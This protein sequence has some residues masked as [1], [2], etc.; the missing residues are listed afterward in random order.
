MLLLFLFVE[1]EMT[2]IFL[3]YSSGGML[4]STCGEEVGEDT[5]LLWL[6]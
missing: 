3:Q 5:T 2:S 1:Y 6:F 4:H